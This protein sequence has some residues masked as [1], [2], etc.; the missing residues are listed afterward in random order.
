MPLTL[1][2]PPPRPALLL[3][4]P[5]LQGRQ[6]PQPQLLR[7]VAQQLAAGRAGEQELLWMKASTSRSSVTCKCGWK[8]AL[9]VLH[10]S[11]S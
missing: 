1:L 8:G 9:G 4:C 7:N 10:R 3:R 5:R 2:V 11:W 6:G